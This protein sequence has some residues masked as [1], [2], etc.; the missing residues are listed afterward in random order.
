MD[1]L[2]F[3]VVESFFV[4]PQIRYSMIFWTQVKIES[5]LTPSTRPFYKI[6]VISTFNG[7][8]FSDSILRLFSIHELTSACKT[9]YIGNKLICRIGWNL[10]FQNICIWIQMV[11]NSQAGE[12]NKSFVVREMKFLYSNFKQKMSMEHM[13]DYFGRKIRNKWEY[14][15]LKVNGLPRDNSPEWAK[16]NPGSVG[17]KIEF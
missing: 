16:F 12:K 5:M 11:F 14:G 3:P 2:G 15:R 7:L 13:Q 8:E 10:F 17:V 9:S 6:R 4:D 1:F